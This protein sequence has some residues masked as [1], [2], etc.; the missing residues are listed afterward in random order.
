[1][2]MTVRFD[3]FVLGI[4]GKFFSFDGI[5]FWSWSS[6]LEHLEMKRERTNRAIRIAH[7]MGLKWV[8]T[9]RKGV[10]VLVDSSP[11]NCVLEIIVQSYCSGQHLRR[12]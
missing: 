9:D 7:S 6:C 2:D 10:R 3:Q 12:M 11:F 4:S 1:M 5:R 8:N